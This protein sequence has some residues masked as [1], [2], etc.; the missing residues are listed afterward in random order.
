TTTLSRRSS[1]ACI[2][3][4]WSGRNPAKPQTRWS[5]SSS[6]T[7]GTAPV[8]PDLGASGV[9][10]LDVVVDKTL[11]LGGEVVVG[12][13]Q[14]RDVAAADV[15][16]ATRFFAGS[17]KTD[18]DARR[19]RLARPVDDATHDGQRHLFDPL[20]RRLPFGHPVADVRLYPFGQLLKRRA[21]R[22]TAA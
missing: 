4:R 6:A 5:A 17:G 3:S 19:L 2:A 11:E 10:P 22:P 9:L 20:V 16:G 15:D 21:R 12:A 8:T 7:S 18:A 1:T 13:A 14:V